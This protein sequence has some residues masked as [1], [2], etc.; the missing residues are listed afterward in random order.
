MEPAITTEK[1]KELR[2]SLLS[3]VIGA[4]EMHRAL[5]LS[6]DIDP[7]KTVEEYRE[8]LADRGVFGGLNNADT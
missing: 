1:I 2:E 6:G 7:A 5:S 3:G 8:E 4:D